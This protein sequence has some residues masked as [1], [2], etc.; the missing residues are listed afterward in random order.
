MPR[1]HTITDSK[2]V[3]STEVEYEAIETDPKPN[4]KPACDV[5]MDANPAYQATN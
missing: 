1:D 3:Q 2:H 4:M 5:I